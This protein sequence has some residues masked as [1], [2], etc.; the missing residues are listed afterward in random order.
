MHLYGRKF[1]DVTAVI[2]SRSA[3]LVAIV[4]A[5]AAFAVIGAPSAVADS[6][7][8]VAL[9]SSQVVSG[10]EVDDCVANPNANT[11]SD[12]PGVDVELEGGLGI[13]VG[14]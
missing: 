13:G 14:G 2:R 11:T 7:N 3:R 12:V 6:A 5:A 10:V 4:G 1:V 9:C 8:R